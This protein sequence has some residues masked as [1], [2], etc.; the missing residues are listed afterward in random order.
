MS[1]LD[2]WS[3]VKDRFTTALEFIE[4]LESRGIGLDFGNAPVGTA[5]DLQKHAYDFVQIDPQALENARRE[6]LTNARRHIKPLG[7]N[8]P[9]EA[10]RYKA[11]RRQE[12]KIYH[13]V[14]RLGRDVLCTVV[15]HS[16]AHGT[17][18]LKA[19]GYGHRK[20][21]MPADHWSEAPGRFPERFKAAGE[22]VYVLPP[23]R[24]SEEFDRYTKLTT[25]VDLTTWTQNNV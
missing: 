21:E 14:L 8:T 18:L 22:G 23:G 25:P 16:R 13:G 9:E 24:Y 15:A 17:R 1:V 12:L 3:L 4:F 20:N 6:L 2:D 7:R 11:V 10:T 19:I 5:L